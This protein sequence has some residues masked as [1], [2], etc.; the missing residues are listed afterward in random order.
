MSLRGTLS[1]LGLLSKQAVT[2]GSVDVAGAIRKAQK[3]KT[4]TESEDPELEDGSTIETSGEE[5]E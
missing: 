5:I 2:K 4:E 1:F 3:E